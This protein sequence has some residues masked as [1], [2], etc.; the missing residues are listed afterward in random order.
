MQSWRY[1]VE[2]GEKQRGCR[3]WGRFF[4]EPTAV[5]NGKGN[6]T[7]LSRRATW[8]TGDGACDRTKLPSPPQ[9]TPTFSW[10][11]LVTPLLPDSRDRTL[12]Y[13]KER[14][15]EGDKMNWEGGKEH[16]EVEGFRNYDDWVMSPVGVFRG[17]SKVDFEM[18][19]EETANVVLYDR[20]CPGCGL[21]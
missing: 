1:I 12:T 11:L 9:R 20:D 17:R 13:E 8:R 15:E 16:E 3:W 4:F 5:S 7:L 19:L 2:E 10:P 21:I 18:E 14:G 6:L